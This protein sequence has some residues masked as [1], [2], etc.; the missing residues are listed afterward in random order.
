MAQRH[1]IDFKL[2]LTRASDE[3]SACQVA[4]LPTIEVGESR[5]PV[6]VSTNNVPSP[7]L[8]AALANKSITRRQLVEL[9]K[10]LADCLLPEGEIRTLFKEA[11]HLVKDTE[12]LRLR[13]ILADDALRQWPWEYSYLNLLDGPEAMR[14]F[15]VLDPRI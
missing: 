10:Q 12:G 3:Q 13:L 1:Y 9:G 8:L 6:I 14:G 4:L 5:Q 2:Y 15:L 7:D 11:L